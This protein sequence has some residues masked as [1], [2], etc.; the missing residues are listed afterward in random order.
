MTEGDK[1][2]LSA[3]ARKTLGPIL[4]A[5]VD[6]FSKDEL[7]LVDFVR[8]YHAKHGHLPEFEVLADEFGFE[9]DDIDNAPAEPNFYLEK[10]HRRFVYEHIALNVPKVLRGIKDDPYGARDRLRDILGAEGIILSDSRIVSHQESA[11][12]RFDSYEERK[13]SGG[14][15]HLSSGHPILDNVHG[16]YQKSDLITYAGRSGLGK[17]FWLC[18]LAI[19]AQDALPEDASDILFISNEMPVVELQERMDAIEFQLPYGPFMRGELSEAME[20]YYQRALAHYKSRIKFIQNVRT[21]NELEEYLR[22]LDPSL[23]FL[24]GSYLMNKDKSLATW[25]R[26]QYTTQGI[27]EIIL[28]THTPVINTTQLKR[29]AGKEANAYALDAQDEFAFGGSFIQD[30]DLALSMY[31]NTNMKFRGHVGMQFAKGRRVD[32]ETKLLWRFSLGDMDFDVELDEGHDID[33]TVEI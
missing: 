18:F 2:V 9:P 13:G 17:T 27:K 22:A 30:S 3:V 15:L 10:L 16:G 28:S 14:V 11:F 26:V 31:Q 33:D 32:S 19:M 21:N 4:K 23:C 7:E 12:D 8:D 6:W 1:L 29:G 25:E 5:K 20:L 24:D